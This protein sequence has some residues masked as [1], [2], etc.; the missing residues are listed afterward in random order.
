MRSQCKNVGL[1]I[2]IAAVV[3]CTP[4]A[5][6]ETHL[7]SVRLVDST[8]T[9]QYIAVKV[10]VTSPGR[11]DTIPGVLTFDL[12]SRTIDGVLHG[13]IYTFEGEYD[14]IYSYHPITR[15]FTRR[16]L[17]DEVKWDSEVKLSPDAKHVAYIAGGPGGG[18]GKVL[19]WPGGEPVLETIAAPSPA[20]DFSF[21]QVAWA[22]P[23]SVQFSW[24]VDF[25]NTARENGQFAFIAVYGSLRAKRQKTDTLREQPDFRRAK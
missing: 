9:E 25:G 20:G 21:S 11:V 7:V 2:V 17:P 13:P 12:P 16:A 8:Q 18:R 5:Q 24:D 15:A 14:G 23:D 1:A 19:T 22:T 10:E 3:A 6:R 4:R